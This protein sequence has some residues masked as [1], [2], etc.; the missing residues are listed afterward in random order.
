M[1]ENTIALSEQVAQSGLKKTKREPLYFPIVPK[2]FAFLWFLLQGNHKISYQLHL[3][4]AIVNMCELS[5][6]HVVSPKAGT[7]AF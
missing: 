3:I 6:K 1:A 4:R 2:P 5:I 7:H